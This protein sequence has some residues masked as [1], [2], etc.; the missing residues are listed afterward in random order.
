MGLL[1]LKNSRGLSLR[2][3]LED[4]LQIRA[5]TCRWQGNSGEDWEP[6]KLG[7]YVNMILLI[8]MS[9]EVLTNLEYR[10]I[11]SCEKLSINPY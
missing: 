1:K 8:S 4:H 10:D 6:V 9:F 11:C 5:W 2:R 3:H 7:S